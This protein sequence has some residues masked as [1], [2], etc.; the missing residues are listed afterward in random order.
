TGKY[1]FQRAFTQRTQQ[2]RST[3]PRPGRRARSKKITLR[4]DRHEV[5]LLLTGRCLDPEPR[6]G[7]AAG[8]GGSDSG[9]CELLELIAIDLCRP[10]FMHGK[11]VVE[12]E[13]C[14][15]T[16]LAVHE[17]CPAACKVGEPGNA[18]RVALRDDEALLA[19]H[20]M[21]QP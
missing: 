21:Q 11:Q 2:S 1:L 14:A 12:Q 7:H 13:S 19:R 6:L 3:G 15:G 9:M 4:R 5:E 8:D 10:D 20:E 18:E 16:G 17:P